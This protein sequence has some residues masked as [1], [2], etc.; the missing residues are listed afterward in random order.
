[1]TIELDLTPLDAPQC[2]ADP[3]PLFKTDR[4]LLIAVLAL[5]LLL[6]VWK[7]GV[8]LTG[9][10]IW[11]EAHF[12]VL[13][14]RPGLAYPDIPAGW[15]LFAKL[16]T[17]LFGWSAPAIRIP[18]LIVAEA[19]PLAVYWLARAVVTPREALWAAM[20]ALVTPA[21]SVSGVIFYP[22]EGLQIALAVL[23]GA[24]IR[25]MQGRGPGRGLAYWVLAGAAGALGLLIHFR[26]VLVGAGVGLFLL[27]APKGRAQWRRP[28]LWLAA[29]IA[30]LGLLPSLIYNMAEHWPALTY[31]VTNR[32]SYR[33]NPGW[34]LTFI[35][36]QL[37]LATPAVLL[38]LAA[39]AGLAWREA[40]RD[41][42]VAALLLSVAGPIFG[43][44][45]AL[46]LVDSQVMPHWPW[47][48]YVALIPL[49]PGVLIR[50]VDRATTIGARRL[51]M[52]AI[53]LFGPV[54][55]LVGGVGGTLFEWGWAHADQLPVADRPLL[56][57]RLEDWRRMEPALAR[58]Q[59]EAHRRFGG[60]PVIAA[61][62]HISALR[63]EFPGAPGRAVYAL[64]EPYDE[65]TRF[66]VIRRAWGLDEAGL[67]RDH[68]GGA[69]VL[70]L[71]EPSYLYNTPGELAFRRRLCAEFA[72]IAA[73]ETVE[74]PPGRTAVELYTARVGTPAAGVACPL[75]PRLYIAQPTRAAV[76][77]ARET[78]GG[79]FGLAADPKGIAKVEAVLD[80]RPVSTAAAPVALPSAPPVPEFNN[81]PGYPA[82][83]YSYALPAPAL[84]PGAHRL[85]LRA[86][87]KDGTVRESSTRTL[88]VR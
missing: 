87:L 16:C 10:V 84:T 3:R 27:A 46:S 1:M 64:D 78:K 14:Q 63:L 49:A 22:E 38:T 65:F 86:T 23:L 72:D 13:G 11:E 74:L 26:F 19:I 20:L 54:V 52:A 62:G 75:L 76:V 17:T 36:N 40:R 57:T 5:G 82:I 60:S 51:R 67:K 53:A 7:L 50:F 18:G 2:R 69:V 4:G 79:L 39:S 6:F 45:A 70:A 34:L 47:L 43:L 28:G 33:F 25:A 41:N 8:A 32:P 30:A 21:L 29:A 35:E 68:G 48:A 80:G 83:W 42:G 31:Q 73:T 71:P 66:A 56:F 9:N 15:P 58:A 61:A 85:S 55:A 12:A 37:G 44:Y 24:L 59:A 81:N 77:K 88:Y